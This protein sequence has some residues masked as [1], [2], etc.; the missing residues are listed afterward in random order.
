MDHFCEARI[1]LYNSKKK[2]SGFRFVINLN[3]MKACSYFLTVTAL[4]AQ[5]YIFLALM[6]LHWVE[7]M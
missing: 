4:F 2:S 5:I 7:E 6:I 3:D 1:P